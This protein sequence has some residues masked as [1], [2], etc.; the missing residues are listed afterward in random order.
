MFISTA[1]AA[2]TGTA[3]TA[4]AQG[5]AAGLLM[6]FLPLILVIFIFYFFLV[7]PQQKRMA[8]FQ[9]MVA[10]LRRGDRVVTTGG[11]IGTIHRVETHSPEVIVEIAENVRVRVQRS[12]IAE[13]L[14]KTEPVAGEN[15]EKKSA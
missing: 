10:A 8:E 12:A 2:S 15:D 4:S 1:F 6:S 5:G 13:V 11:I 14:A 3:A 7:R 9:K